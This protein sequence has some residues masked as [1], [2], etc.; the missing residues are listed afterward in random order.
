MHS[1]NDTASAAID[2][3]L[4]AVAS[5]RG[6]AA[7]KRVLDEIT[8][9]GAIDTSFVDKAKQAIKRGC[10]EMGIRRYASL[11]SMTAKH[12]S[13]ATSSTKN[14]RKQ[15]QR[16][17]NRKH[18]E[19][20]R[21]SNAEPSSE[22]TVILLPSDDA[23]GM[24]EPVESAACTMDV[25]SNSAPTP[26]LF[27]ADPA[28]L[29]SQITLVAPSSPL[30]LLAQIDADEAGP[31]LSLTDEEMAETYAELA[32]WLLS[33]EQKHSVD[34]ECGL[35]RHPSL[36]SRM[37]PILV[38]W[39][40]EVAADYRMH[41][42]TLHLTVQ[43]LDR[44]LASTDLLVEPRMLQCYGTAC[45]SIAMKAEELRVPTLT[46]FTEFSKDAF[47]REQL[48]SAELDV[49]TALDWHLAVPT[50]H[51]FL[52]LMFQR[53]SLYFPDQFGSSA[54]GGAR[55]LHGWPAICPAT[56]PRRF[57]QDQF[58][59]ACDYA[60]VLLHCQESLRHRASELAAACFYLGIAPSSLDGAMFTLCT[61][62]SFAAIWPAIRHLKRLRAI[63]APETAY[64]SLSAQPCC[65]AKDRYST[66]LRR[67]R[68]DEMWAF[69][70]RHAHLLSEFEDYF[71][72][73]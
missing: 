66:N 43:Y 33:T 12:A 56:I 72:A 17:R 37:R 15:I 6:S 26:P 68:S 18:L 7:R 62:Y 47:T 14:A 40:M 13:A 38:D 49:L 39:L 25:R 11:S 8:E 57:D 51:E 58:I 20:Q 55:R 61:G 3:S 64:S 2:L 60:D 32:E 10:T 36:S 1:T 41:R 42:Q 44:F 48:K 31:A 46:E 23:S 70:P 34:L 9:N 21:A 35:A 54:D 65:I 45:L 28:G 71:Y 73:R 24:Q 22:A 59:L 67:I 27:S 53:A 4:A 16:P 69:Q 29:E 52:C 5:A 50:I 63:L 19:A 30:H